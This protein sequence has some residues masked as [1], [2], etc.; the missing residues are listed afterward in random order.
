[1]WTCTAPRRRKWSEEEIDY[2]V[3]LGFARKERK[4][5]WAGVASLVKEKYGFECTL[6]MANNIFYTY[7]ASVR[8]SRLL[9][10]R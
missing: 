4:L 10:T 3:E 1:M 9:R 5:T 8:P 2:V 6:S 7:C